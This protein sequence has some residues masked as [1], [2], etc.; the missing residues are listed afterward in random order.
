MFSKCSTLK[1]LTKDEKKPCS[2]MQL[3]FQ[4]PKPKFRLK[5]I[6]YYSVYANTTVL[7]VAK[8][9]H[10]NEALPFG[11]FYETNFFLRSRKEHFLPCHL[12]I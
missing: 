8:E 2:K 11:I 10:I 3:H 4:N 6:R 9:I 1:N 12:K 7:N 5:D